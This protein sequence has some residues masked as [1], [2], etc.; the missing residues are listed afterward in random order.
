MVTLT[1]TNEAGSAEI[2]KE[3]TVIDPAAAP[4]A[5]FTFE[6]SNLTALFTNT[7]ANATSYSWNFGDG[8]VTSTD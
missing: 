3:V 4:A 8:S 6:T 1:A 5:G 2:T 7:S